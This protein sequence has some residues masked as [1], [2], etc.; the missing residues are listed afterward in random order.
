MQS[1]YLNAIQMRLFNI[2]QYNSY[3]FILIKQIAAHT[4]MEC[5]IV[6]EGKI[7]LRFHRN[8]VGIL[9]LTAH[10]MLM[11]C[12]CTF[13]CAEC[14]DFRQIYTACNQMQYS[15]IVPSSLAVKRFAT[16]SQTNAHSVNVRTAFSRR[17]SFSGNKILLYFAF[18][19]VVWYYF[20][21]STQRQFTSRCNK[22]LMLKLN[23][24]VI[25]HTLCTAEL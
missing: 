14:L 10:F 3:L 15:A 16:Q 1:H 2:H 13:Q 5:F 21:I 24:I 22:L 18:G 8:F 11:P 4:T 25:P 17:C 23:K 20:H 9:A 12:A 7:T 19:A 6:V